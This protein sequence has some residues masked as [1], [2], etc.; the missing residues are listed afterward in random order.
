MAHALGGQLTLTLGNLEI[1]PHPLLDLIRLIEPLEI[2][3]D[4][5]KKGTSALPNPTWWNMRDGFR[6]IL[7]EG[8]PYFYYLGRSP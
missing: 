5:Q 4:K 7:D 1:R 2:G 6:R 8:H 3:S